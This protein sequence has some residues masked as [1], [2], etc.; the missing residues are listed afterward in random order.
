MMK[1]ISEESKRLDT[2]T[3]T[4]RVQHV[5]A[6]FRALCASFLAS[7]EGKGHLTNR[8]S[9]L[10]DVEKLRSEVFAE[11][12]RK[13]IPEKDSDRWKNVRIVVD[14]GSDVN[15]ESELKP[16]LFAKVVTTAK[17]LLP[18]LYRRQTWCLF[19]KHERVLL[20]FVHKGISS[21]DEAITLSDLN[22]A[23]KECG[24]EMF[25]KSVPWIGVG[26]AKEPNVNLGSDEEL[27]FSDEDFCPVLGNKVYSV[28]FD[29]TIS[30]FVIKAKDWSMS[31]CLG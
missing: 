24:K 27:E 5:I 9:Y 8:G 14:Y 15:N 6:R 28:H 30:S 25:S 23:Y 2:T 19:K 22:S 16:V 17:P 10:V 13:K 20:L 29:D 7:P 3:K 1:R 11:L 4:N 18:R 26:A 12:V 21:L 31:L